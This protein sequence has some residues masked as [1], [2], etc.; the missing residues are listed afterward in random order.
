MQVAAALKF[1]VEFNAIKLLHNM[2]EGA[3]I[4][5]AHKRLLFRIALLVFKLQP[6]F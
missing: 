6:T 5:L 2:V 4:I 1:Q 3:L